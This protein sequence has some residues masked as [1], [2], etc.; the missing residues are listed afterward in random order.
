MDRPLHLIHHEVVGSSE[1][2]G[3]RT[4]GTRA[5]GGEGEGQGGRDVGKDLDLLLKLKK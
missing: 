5:E 4:T 2:D 3:G 1:D